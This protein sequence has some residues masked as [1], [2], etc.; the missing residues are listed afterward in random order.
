MCRKYSMPVF[1]ALFLSFNLIFRCDSGISAEFWYNDKLMQRI[2][3]DNEYSRPVS[4]PAETS[5]TVIVPEIENGMML[6][7]IYHY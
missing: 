3:L 7:K 6:F 4:L 1:L 2:R 5:T